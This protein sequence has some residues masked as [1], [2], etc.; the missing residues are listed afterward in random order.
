MHPAATPDAGPFEY[1]DCTHLRQIAEVVRRYEVGTIYHLA[2]L[3][4]AVAEAK[5]CVAW[6][7]NRGGLYRVLEVARG[8]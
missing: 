1:V 5:P 4:S 2:A 3:L 7:I 6:D 8:G